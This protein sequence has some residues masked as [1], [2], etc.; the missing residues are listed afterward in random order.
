MARLCSICS[1]PLVDAVNAALLEHRHGYG[2]IAGFFGLKRTSLQRHAATHLRAVIAE[3]KEL[4]MALSA[5]NLLDKLSELDAATRD[6]LVE[7]RT[8]GDLRTA[9]IAV[10][11]SRENISAYARWGIM[12]DLEA[13]L[14]ALEHDDRKEGDNDGGQ[15]R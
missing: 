13:R 2:Y 3:S 15:S 6:M 12:S 9:L 11:E 7:A 4:R 10:R 14:E 8:A 1:S 5:D